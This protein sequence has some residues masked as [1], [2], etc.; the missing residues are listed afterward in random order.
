[1]QFFDTCSSFYQF[2]SWRNQFLSVSMEDLLNLSTFLFIAFIIIKIIIFHGIKNL[3]KQTWILDRVCVKGFFGNAVDPF[4]CDSYYKCP[5][6]L[7]F[8]CDIGTEFDGD[9]GVCVPIT[10]NGC[11][12]VAENR[13]VN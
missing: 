3:Q 10:D 6:G 2:L 11:S 13:L 12:A 7:K 8:Y 4:A 5:E 1:M 9:R